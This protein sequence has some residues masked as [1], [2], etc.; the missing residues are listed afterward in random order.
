MGAEL[1]S[2][3]FMLNFQNEGTTFFPLQEASQ[4]ELIIEII[5]KGQETGQ[6]KNSKNPVDLYHNMQNL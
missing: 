4:K 3:V 2:V 6:F 5:K 1:L